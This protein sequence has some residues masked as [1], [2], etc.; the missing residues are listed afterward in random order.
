MTEVRQEI[1]P[2][3]IAPPGET[4]AAGHGR[5][6][7]VRLFNSVRPFAKTRKFAASEAGKASTS[8]S[9]T[10]LSE[11]QLRSRGFLVPAARRFAVHGGDFLD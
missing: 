3:A 8:L 1:F 5:A 4:H 11:L 10:P 2:H 9:N 7:L 6:R